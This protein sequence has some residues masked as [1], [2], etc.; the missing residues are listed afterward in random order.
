MP[1]AVKLDRMAVPSTVRGSMRDIRKTDCSAGLN[2]RAS[3]ICHAVTSA[4]QLD[5]ADA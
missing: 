4:L 2:W 5:A 1:A 3:S